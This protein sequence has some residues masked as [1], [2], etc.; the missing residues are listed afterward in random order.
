MQRPSEKRSL[1]LILR[2]KI[3]SQLYAE[4]TESSMIRLHK[5]T[6]Y[7]IINGMKGSKLKGCTKRYVLRRTV[8]H[9]SDST[10]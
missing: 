9:R 1:T 5:C 4:P 10:A 8:K 7:G 2:V 6:K 3:L